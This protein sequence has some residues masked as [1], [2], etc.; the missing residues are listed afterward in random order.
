MESVWQHC[1]HSK[2][3]SQED[4]NKEYET[5]RYFGALCTDCS[6]TVSGPSA[7]GHD[8]PMEFG[9]EEDS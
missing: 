8:M 7:L 9:H 4:S 1:K 3:Q 5:A 2:E 6:T